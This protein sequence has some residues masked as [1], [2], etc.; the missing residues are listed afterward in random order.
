[1]AD[2][3]QKLKVLDRALEAFE[4]DHDIFEALSAKRRKWSELIAAETELPQQIC[5]HE[6]HGDKDE[7]WHGGEGECWRGDEGF[8]SADKPSEK[9][10]PPTVWN[11]VP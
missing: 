11:V 10:E 4:G 5:E 3:V 7:W 1:M 8:W 6:R 2:F 9:V